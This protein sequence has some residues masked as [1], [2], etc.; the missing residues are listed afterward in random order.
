MKQYLRQHY[1]LM[2]RYKSVYYSIQKKN[3]LFRTVFYLIDADNPP[4]RRDSLD[5]LFHQVQLHDGAF[6]SEIEAFIEVPAWN[7]CSWL[8]YEAIRHS[9]IVYNSEIEFY[10]KERHYWIAHT[11]NGKSHLSDNLGNVQYFNS[12]YDLFESARIGNKKLQE[13]WDEVII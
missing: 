6:L 2:F 11:S 8:C 5:E 1:F 10:Y 9:V 3:E 12:P 13:I 7:D 4:I